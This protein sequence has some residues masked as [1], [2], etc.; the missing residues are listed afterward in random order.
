MSLILSVHISFDNNYP[1]YLLFQLNRDI[2]FSFTSVKLYD[3]SMFSHL[4]V[5]LLKA[6]D[7]SK[8][9]NYPLL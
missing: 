9:N 1:H 7:A 4:I 3:I 2:T 5:F 8:T 6:H